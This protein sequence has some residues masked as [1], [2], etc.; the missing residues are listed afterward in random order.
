MLVEEN[1]QFSIDSNAGWDQRIVCLKCGELV[2]SYLIRTERFV[3][4]YD[5]LLGPKSGALL[6]DEAL[7]LADGRP[8]L[9]VNSHADWDHYFGNMV[10]DV[11]I[12]GTQAMVERVTGGVGAK[13]LADKRKKHPESYGPVRLRA[14]DVALSAEATLHGG[15]LTLQLL[16]TRGHRPD[17][18]AIYVPEIETLLPGDCVEDP[19]PLVDED[20]DGS[21]R[22]IE[23][24]SQSLKRFLDL[25]PTWVLAN[26]AA[27]EQGVTRIEGNLNYLRK[28]QQAALDSAS[29]EQLKSSWPADDNWDEFYRQA[30]R[31]HL[32]MARQ[33]MNQARPKWADD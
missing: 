19:I 26:H 5:T 9:V 22:T 4:I 23:E 21:S 14:P 11:P 1:L 10:F 18:L 6:R 7:K 3:V 31:S 32:R 33:Q 29:L 20:S 2:R 12:L 28:L 15:D 8:L 13:E 24:L 17:H 27:P 30:H 16:Y 25:K